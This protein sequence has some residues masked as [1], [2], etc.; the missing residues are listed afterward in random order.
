MKYPVRLVL[1][2]TAMLAFTDGSV[3]VGETIREVVDEDAGYALPHLCL[4]EA[5]ALIDGERLPLLHLLAQHTHATVEPADDDW[6]ALGLATRTFGTS[7]RGSAVAATT[8][9]R[10]YLLTATPAD[11]GEMDAVIPV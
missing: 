6:E 11:Y 1:D 3:A 9:H 4:A 2:T 5:V 10:A 7:A 8:R